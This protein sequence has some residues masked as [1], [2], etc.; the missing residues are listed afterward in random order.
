[1]QRIR[2]FVLVLAS[3][4]LPPFA[5]AAVPASERAALVSLYQSTNGD[6]WNDRTHWL[7]EAG[8][9]CNWFGVRCDPSQQSVTA[10]M[11]GG[12]NLTGKLPPEIGALSRLTA[13]D[14]G[15]NAIGGT[16]PP[17]IAQLTNLQSLVLT[18]NHLEGDLPAALFSL[19][20][21]T[22]LRLGANRFGGAIPS[23]IGQ[24]ANLVSLDLSNN[25]LR[26]EAPVALQ[27][28]GHLGI[29]A[30]D[31]R[32]NAIA[33][34]DPVL[35]AYL[36]QK[37]A[38]GDIRGSQTL[39]PVNVRADLSH[40]PFASPGDVIVSWDLAAYAAD[41]GGYQITATDTDLKLV[42]AVETTSSK[43]LDDIL[44]TGTGSGSFSFV[45]RTV[46]H[47]HG[48]QQN[49]ITSEPSNAA[50]LSKF[51]YAPPYAWVVAGTPPDILAQ[52]GPAAAN[53]VTYTIVNIGT[54]ETEITLAQTGSFFTQSP[55]TFLLPEGSS[56]TITVTA[57]AQ[58]AGTYDGASL[59][60]G[61]GVFGELAIP[62]TLVSTAPV[63]GTVLGEP[64]KLRVDVAAARGSN[65][66]GTASFV[67]RGS[68]AL[69]GVV[70]SDAAWIVP[71]SG[72]V[73]IP[74]GAS[75]DVT[76]TVD[77]SKRPD[78][79]SEN[80]A[81]FSASLTL[82]YADPAQG[83]GLKV[84]PYDAGGTGSS[85]SLVSVIDTVKPPLASSPIPSLASGELA[86]FVPGIA[87]RVRA[88]GELLSDCSIANAFGASS[89]SDLKLY[90]T[91]AG[92]GT[93]TSVA[94]MGA[95]GPRGSLLLADAVTTV[96]G[97]QDRSGSLQ[98]RSLDANRLL[99]G[100]RLVTV[101]VGR[102]TIG[103][104]LPVYRS[105]RSA[106]PGEEI[107]LAGI[108]NDATES[109]LVVQ[110]T[111]GAEARVRIEYLDATG[112]R[113]SLVDPVTIGGFGSVEYRGS[114][115]AK[116][117]TALVTNRSDSAGRIV[118]YGLN[119]D[120]SSG[121]LWIVNDWS[122]LSGF[123][124]SAAQKV[125]Y[126]PLRDPGAA[127]RRPVRRGSAS[128]RDGE[129][130]TSRTTL[131][132]TAHNASGAPAT[133]SITYYEN[134]SAIGRKAISLGARETRTIDDV[135]ASLFGR[136]GSATGWLA[137]EP[138]RNTPLA[139]SARIVTTGA[140]P[141][142]ASV[143]VSTL[144]SGLRLGQAQLLAGIDDTRQ[145]TIDAK[146]G[147]TTS[148]T[149]GFA[150]TAGKSATLRVSMLYVDGFSLAATISTR[151]FTVGAN[152][153]LLIPS[154]ARAIVGDARETELGDLRD[155]QLEIRVIAGEGAITPFA[156]AADNGSGD[157]IV[158][159]E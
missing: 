35:R 155:I 8:T 78:S 33:I 133:A 5:G 84:G 15:V 62:I 113:V 67:N 88:V 37:Q 119:L 36:E 74:A 127:R 89:I 139:L 117:A 76:F 99:T 91:P 115:P 51:F 86:L 10:L 120:A 17:Q 114:V 156:I 103:T 159:L 75:R 143:P 144:S 81:A 146:R 147:G 2:A 124:A 145:S 98:V 108:G 96:Y 38:G 136:S 31:L 13:L 109:D 30:L 7:R 150:E 90:F 22:S 93:A 123:D 11:L 79:Y 6:Q 43:E 52:T 106:K 53:R 137:V 69:N 135:V 47:S 70:R 32:Y 45:V 64:S 128:A 61:D 63:A 55:T 48:L 154:I 49:T 54:L 19:T 18:E 26:G 4:A 68:A 157:A 73:T 80:G 97:Q 158:R 141:S 42:K 110:E 95:V 40:D 142:T 12:N 24:L 58:P 60:S 140:S 151:E 65:A 27:S 14:L 85:T 94:S 56:R 9:E 111:S 100:A 132:L 66:A 92:D 44:L 129:A 23:A 20:A 83:D 59:V 105:T 126:A 50:L 116:A 3:L 39:P 16:L 71:Q 77:R 118:A 102:G 149:L 148:T 152:Q 153:L 125:V 72:L 82:D 130:E 131:E 28:L 122:R 112:A 101:K 29:G 21:L 138:Q 25:Q 107:R 57:S 87:H 46:T 104:Q 1:M 41:P 121:D 134:G 34:S